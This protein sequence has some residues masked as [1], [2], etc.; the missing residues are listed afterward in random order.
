MPDAF[1]VPVDAAEYD[2]GEQEEWEPDDDWLANE[3]ERIY[4][5][6]RNDTRAAVG[7]VPAVVLDL[8]AELRV[9]SYNVDG[10]YDED[11]SWGGTEFFRRD[12]REAIAEARLTLARLATLRRP[13]IAALGSSRGPSRAPR[14]V[15]RRRTRASAR[16]PG[17]LA[18]DSEPEPPRPPARR[19]RAIPRAGE[20]A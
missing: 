13:P 9:D 8:A 2:D 5:V 6:A 17:R 14:R 7:P 16:S 19:Q 12:P 15:V 3:A 11:G 20:D 1:E 18:D 10:E 4:C